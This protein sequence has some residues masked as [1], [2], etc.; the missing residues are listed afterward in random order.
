MIIILETSITLKGTELVTVK[1]LVL[2]GTYKCK[3]KKKNPYYQLQVKKTIYLC[4]GP[5]GQAWR[6]PVPSVR[7]PAVR[8]QSSSSPTP[9]V[10]R[11]FCPISLLLCPSVRLGAW[12]SLADP[13][14][15]KRGTLT[16]FHPVTLRL[17]CAHNLTYNSL[18]ETDL[19]KLT[20]AQQV[21]NLSVLYGTRSFVTVFTRNSHFTMSG[22]RKRHWK[23]SRPISSS[24]HIDERIK[25]FIHSFV[26]SFVR[27]FIH[28]FVGSRIAP[29]T[30]SVFNRTHPYICEQNSLHFIGLY[31]RFHSTPF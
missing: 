15:Q 24:T 26:R 1:F 31:R 23:P 16:V 4:R 2:C 21:S 17:Y 30:S 5:W 8:V 25:S 22:A 18:P 28:S 27:S 3:F 6:C 19:D 14:K 13:L 11:T 29:L 10:R 12:S 7:R 9:H 20:V